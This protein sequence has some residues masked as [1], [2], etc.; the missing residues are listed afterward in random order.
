MR[1]CV[2][3]SIVHPFITFLHKP[4][5]LG[6]LWRY[7]HQTGNIYCYEKCM[8]K[9]WPHFE[10]KEWP[11]SPIV[12]CQLFINMLTPDSRLSEVII[13]NRP[14]ISLKMWKQ[15]VLSIFCKCQIWSLIPASRFSWVIRLKR[16]FI[17]LLLLLI[18]ARL[19]PGFITQL[20]INIARVVLV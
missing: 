4:L 19:S 9:N 18:I 7:P 20:E 8:S 1:V 6:Y 5:Y 12:H 13:L 3:A 15:P 17:S 16:L 10:K 11:Q 14:Y 2:C